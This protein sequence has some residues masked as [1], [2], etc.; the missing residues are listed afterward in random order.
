MRGCFLLTDG[1]ARDDLDGIQRSSVPRTADVV[2]LGC[3]SDDFTLPSHDQPRH[4]LLM[5]G[6]AWSACTATC[7]GATTTV[8]IGRGA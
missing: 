1:D 7:S 8:W 2:V 5:D 4:P 6:A 3:A